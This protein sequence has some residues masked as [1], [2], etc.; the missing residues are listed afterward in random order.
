MESLEK[1]HNSRFVTLQREHSERYAFS[2]LDL[3]LG[4]PH[5]K[6]VG[7]GE[8]VFKRDC[9]DRC[10]ESRDARVVVVGTHD[11]NKPRSF[12]QNV[13]SPRDP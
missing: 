10:P 13:S 6:E 12:Y 5:L 8:V 11:I 7:G 1:G 9:L 3:K 2:C 4:I